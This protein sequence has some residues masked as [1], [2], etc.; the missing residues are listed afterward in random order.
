[1]N[2][3][4]ASRGGRCCSSGQPNLFDIAELGR[5]YRGRVCFV[6]PV[7]YQTISISGTREDI[8]RV[9]QDYQRH[10]GGPEGGLIGY[11]EE[12]QSIGL[13][14]QNYRAC[15]DAFR[16]IGG[17]HWPEAQQALAH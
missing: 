12:Y 15:I 3:D 9:V 10:L 6:L 5:C 1:V 2:R 16:S 11:I 7:S 14:E 4:R 13:S 17:G 8:F